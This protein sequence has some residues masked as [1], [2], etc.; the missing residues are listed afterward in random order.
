MIS[1]GTWSLS[2]IHQRMAPLLMLG[3]FTQRSVKGRYLAN[4]PCELPL[5]RCRCS[6]SST[7]TRNGNLLAGG[8]SGGKDVSGV[9]LWWA[10]GVATR[11]TVWLRLELERC[12]NRPRVGRSLVWGS[13]ILRLSRRGFGFLSSGASCLGGM[14]L[15]SSIDSELAGLKFGASMG[16]RF[17]TVIEV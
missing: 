13:S 6:N 1:N 7:N 3:T 9:V 2:R 4:R 15:G 8:M 5:R 14:K 12:N 10:G 16:F 17:T 11:F